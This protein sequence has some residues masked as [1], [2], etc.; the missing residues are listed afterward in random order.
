[1]GRIRRFGTLKMITRRAVL[2]MPV[3]HTF[4]SRD[5]AKELEPEFEEP[6]TSRSMGYSLSQINQNNIERIRVYNPRGMA[7]RKL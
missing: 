4:F 7:W 5:L 1:M 2:E 6:I 3:G